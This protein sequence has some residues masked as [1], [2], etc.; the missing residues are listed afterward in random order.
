VA[1]VCSDEV[2]RLVPD[3]AA[4]VAARLAAGKV[5]SGVGELMP[6]FVPADEVGR[7]REPA[8]ANVDL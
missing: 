7:S 8:Q 1:L 4:A 2:R 6:P 3:Y 5:G